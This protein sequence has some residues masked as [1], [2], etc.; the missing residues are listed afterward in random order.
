MGIQLAWLCPT[1]KNRTTKAHLLICV[2]I[3][4]I[5]E[6]T[7]FQQQSLHESKYKLN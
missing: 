7:S 4:F 6:S 5:D 3:F 1:L 2:I